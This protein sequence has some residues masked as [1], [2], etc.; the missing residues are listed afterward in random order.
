MGKIEISE[1]ESKI[2]EFIEQ[3]INSAVEKGI[4]QKTIDAIPRE[5]ITYDTK[6]KNTR[7]LIKNYRRFLSACQQATWTECELETATV[8]EV[9]DKL[10]CTTSDEVTVVQS[11]LASKK[12][13]EIII[14]HVKRIIKFY[15]YE[16]ESSNNAEKIRRAHLIDDLYIK[17]DKKP[18]T[19]SMSEKYHISERQISR[20]QN[21]AIEEIAILMF[22]IDGI[23]KMF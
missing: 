8:D 11:I 5:K 7:L 21:T 20:D 6:L 16:A 23:R 4:D 2:L 15:I 1:K 12:R 18:K 22:G 17:G 19:K 9:L 10:Y 13:T 14:E 3:L